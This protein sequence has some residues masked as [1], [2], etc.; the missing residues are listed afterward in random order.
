M[1]VAVVI[2]VISVVC[3]RVGL[4]LVLVVVLMSGASWRHFICMVSML[5]LWV[6]LPVLLIHSLMILILVT[7]IIPIQRLALDHIKWTWSLGISTSPF[8]LE[9]NWLLLSLS[10][11]IALG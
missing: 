4:L 7:H 1:I 3:V 10:K 2:V 8:T 11:L 6:V 9:P 5:L